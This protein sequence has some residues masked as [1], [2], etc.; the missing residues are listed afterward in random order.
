MRIYFND[1]RTKYVINKRVNLDEYHEP[2][3]RELYDWI[4]EETDKKD[5]WDAVPWE[6]YDYF[7]TLQVFELKSVV[8]YKHRLAKVEKRWTALHE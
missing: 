7:E 5:Q 1:D 4:E 6:A 2:E 3:A 8:V